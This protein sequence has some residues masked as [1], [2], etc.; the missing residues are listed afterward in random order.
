[1]A[2][3]SAS[4]LSPLFRQGHTRVPE[5]WGLTGPAGAGL[6]WRAADRDVVATPLLLRRAAALPDDGERVGLLLATEPRF[7][8]RWLT[9]MALRLADLGRRDDVAELCRQID[10]LGAGAAAVHD[11]LERRRVA[12][13]PDA[14]LELSLF[15]APAD[16]PAAA[17]GLLRVLGTTAAL[18]EGGQGQ[19]TA[20]LRPVDSRDP[21]V[22][23]VSG[24]LLQMPGNLA[25]GGTAV[26]PG[27]VTRCPDPSDSAT[28]MAWVLETPWVTLLAVLAF[29][30][31]AWA[32]ERQGGLQLELPARWVR[33]F[34]RPPEIDVV[35]TLADG[36][37]LLCGTL[38]ELCLRAL[39]ALGMAIVPAIDTLA[40]D[41]V[42]GTVVAE[43][44]RAG[45]WR[46]KPEERI[47]YFIADGFGFDCY[48]GE[49][50]RHIFL[51]AETLSQTLRSVTV[52]WAKAR[53]EPTMNRT[54]EVDR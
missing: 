54:G 28:R 43:L 51:G 7:R 26:L 37:E 42:L 53:A 52:T 5:A 20:A 13:A 31:E 25:S 39:D 23:W 21:D 10:A 1:M 40:L 6:W 9:V 12:A 44:L 24:R 22:N 3:P 18:V 30:A 32:A 17:P 36:Q 48:R 50:H 11:R 27:A 14:A 34:A 46:F 15:G 41:R 4:V 49:G 45:A 29:T 38:G 35:V 19:E 16:Q 47:R 33:D 2:E 8:D